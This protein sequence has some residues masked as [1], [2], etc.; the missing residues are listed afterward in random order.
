MNSIVIHIY[1]YRPAWC[2]LFGTHLKFV[3]EGELVYLRFLFIS[4][5]DNIQQQDRYFQVIFCL[6][7]ESLFFC[8]FLLLLFV[9]NIHFYYLEH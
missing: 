7:F 1:T 4:V 3:F 9:V 2:I 8:L 6:I 5:S